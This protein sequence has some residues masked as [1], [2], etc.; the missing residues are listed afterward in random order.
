MTDQKKRKK[1]PVR[2]IERKYSG[3]VVAVWRIMESLIKE[4]HQHL[5]DAKIALAYHRGWNED[6]DGRLKLGT[7]AKGSDLHRQ[8]HGF[9]FVITLN[10]NVVPNLK[11]D[12]VAAIIDHE[13]CHARPAMDTDGEQRFDERGGACWR[14]RRHDIE[15]FSDVVA[16]HGIYMSSLEKMA[17]ALEEARTR[18][19]L[20]AVDKPAEPDEEPKAVGPNAWQ[21]L[22]LSAAGING[23]VG[24]L[25]AEAGI[26]T[27][28]SLAKR[29]A[30]EGQ[31]WWR[32]ITGIGEGTA[33]AVQDRMVVFWKEHPEYC[34]Q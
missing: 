21:A 5:A 23:K 28:G 8:M 2:L 15:E 11:E 9:D 17:A 19:L 12:Q 22:P 25:L 4:H 24:K 26:E 3:K 18:P 14:I 13:L 27:I 31:W 1:V 6:A 16:R 7:C 30:G 20:A 32:P 33:E 10:E 29:T 34:K